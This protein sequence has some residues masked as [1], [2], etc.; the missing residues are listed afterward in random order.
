MLCNLSSSSLGFPAAM[1]QMKRRKR[2]A[3]KKTIKKGKVAHTWRPKKGKQRAALAPIRRRQKALV[4]NYVPSEQAVNQGRRSLRTQ[5][6][7]VDAL[8]LGCMKESDMKS[9]LVGQKLA[10]DWTDKTCPWCKQSKL[11]KEKSQW[12]WFCCSKKNCRRRTHWLHNH[13]FFSYAGKS[14]DLRPQSLALLCQCLEIPA[15]VAHMLT[16]LNHKAVERLYGGWRKLTAWDSK[17]TQKTVEFGDAKSWT[18]GK[19]DEISLRAHATGGKKKWLRYLLI[20]TRGDRSQSVLHRLEDR[21]VKGKGQGGGGSISKTEWSK[22]GNLNLRD[23]K[24]LLFTDAAKAYRTVK[25]PAVKN[26][27]ICHSARKPGQKAQYSK[28]VTVKVPRSM[29][30]VHKPKKKWTRV[31][32]IKCK[33]G[34]QLADNFFKHLRKSILTTTKNCNSSILDGYVHSFRWRHTRWDK[35]IWAA[36]AEAVQRWY[37]D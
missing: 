19:A 24:F 25:I 31:Q 29:E 10:R 9:F 11:K 2:H 33:L 14:A 37:G 20:L 6:W 16:G 18:Q 32:K 17:T 23:R 22:F 4:V 7:T 5:K 36:T 1:K 35:D 27:H 13:P 8:K 28:T 12:Q 15:G 30:Q 21:V 34:S 3:V 26:F